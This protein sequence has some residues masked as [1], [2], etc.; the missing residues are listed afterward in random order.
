[1]VISLTMVVFFI[2][3]IYITYCFISDMMGK[4]NAKSRLVFC[5][6]LELF[7]AYNMIVNALHNEWGESIVDFIVMWIIAE[8]CKDHLKEFAKKR[9]NRKI[10]I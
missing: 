9:K 6:I 2:T 10:L 7:F 1:M 8:S 3:V 4:Y 5:I